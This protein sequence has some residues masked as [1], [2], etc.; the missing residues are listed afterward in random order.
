MNNNQAPN[1]QPLSPYAQN[2][3]TGQTQQFQTMDQARTASAN[4]ATAYAQ[5]RNTQTSPINTVV[6]T[7]NGIFNSSAQP[8]VQS[9]SNQ[10]VSNAFGG[11]SGQNAPSPAPQSQPASQGGTQSTGSTPS[12]NGTD[13]GGFL[14][15]LSSMITNAAGGQQN[16]ANASL[17]LG[18]QVYNNTLQA[19]QSNYNAGLA[20]LNASY[21]NDYQNLMV[22]HQQQMGTALT[23]IASLDPYGNSS[24][25]AQ[26]YVGQMNSLFG[27]ASAQLT[28][29]YN[30]QQVALQNG[31]TQ[32]AIAAQNQ[33]DQT[34]STYNTTMA[35]IQAGM[36]QGLSQVATTG[37]GIAEFGYQ[38]QQQALSLGTSATEQL[39]LPATQLQSS[40]LVSPIK[41]RSG[42]ITGYSIDN[43]MVGALGQAAAGG[44][45]SAAWN[46]LSASQKDTLQTLMQS[47]AY[48]DFIQGGMSP[49][50]AIQ[51][52]AMGSYRNLQT[53]LESQ[54]RILY[55]SQLSKTVGAGLGGGTNFGGSVAPTT[56]F[57]TSTGGGRN[58]DN[59]GLSELQNINNAL[60]PQTLGLVSGYLSDINSGAQTN[61]FNNLSTLAS[62]TGFNIGNILSNSLAGTAAAVG[63][64][65][66]TKS[67]G[68]LTRSAIDNV[69]NLSA[70]DKKKVMGYILNQVSSNANSFVSTYGS[71]GFNLTGLGDLSS[72]LNSLNSL[73]SQTGA[74]T[75]QGGASSG[76]NDYFGQL[77]NTIM[78]AFSNM[79]AINWGASQ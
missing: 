20:Q 39:M 40:G 18:W 29:A 66:G 34:I 25:S 67:D 13:W 50:S 16:A 24:G 53:Q 74:P 59:A 30:A 14:T 4:W 73:L 22:S 47:P 76:T 46:N 31:Q 62:K 78:G 11:L 10:G 70:A 37:L 60:S 19:A 6:Q 75:G 64:A 1:N 38:R 69:N 42:V 49:A 68:T 56:S 77:N 28:N 41:D 8:I 57:I 65:A 43:D 54:S 9:Q 7:P 3:F 12:F 58:L 35:N 23:Q 45:N 2:P 48:Q 52:V 44:Q 21:Q 33:I 32:A 26:A 17:R 27:I 79:G 55:A 36:V 71:Q 15:N 63:V 5:A 51:T 72:K 61:F